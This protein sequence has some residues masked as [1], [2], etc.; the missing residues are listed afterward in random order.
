MKQSLKILKFLFAL[1]LIAVGFG[2]LNVGFYEGVAGLMI[3][4]PMILANIE[5]S[6]DAKQKRSQVYEK[7]QDMVNTRKSEQRSFTADEQIRYDKHKA[8]FDI[9]SNH[10]KEL[11][12]D[13]KRALIMAGKQAK[14]E[15]RERTKRSDWYD[16]NTGKDVIVLGKENRF[17]DIYSDD[18]SSLSVGRAVQGLISGNWRGAEKEERS[19]STAS[20]SG[21]L[22]PLRVFSS[23][24]DRARALSVCLN[25]GAKTIL[26]ETGSMT[27]AR[28]TNDASMQIK[29]ENDQ[30]GSNDIAFGGISLSAHTIGGVVTLSRE[31]ASDAPNVSQ[32]IEQALA[33]AIAVYLDR[34]ALTGTGEG[35]PRGIYNTIG[36]NDVVV[37]TSIHYGHLLRAW[38]EIANKNGKPNAVALNPKEFAILA[39][40]YHVGAGFIDPPNIIKDMQW[41]HSSSIPT[42]LGIGEDES[43]GFVG[44]FT[45]MFF[46]IREGVNIEV[47]REGGEKFS[48]HQVGVKITLRADVGIEQPS[49]FSKL[50][51]IESDVEWWNFMQGWPPTNDPE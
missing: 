39:G 12:D 5:T 4:A 6:D 26:M 21:L 38:Y 8:D 47:T 48:R 41:L 22:V 19:L 51:G 24:I 23:I 36:V 49:H 3:A 37:G 34:L 46:G 30:F 43:A 14:T 42:N 28:V 31:L 9:L 13:E 20:G 1:L 45:K 29:A 16:I 17:A 18:D 7:M 27:L 10:V 25:A 35:E 15:H 40:S 44:D 11:E 50:T 33:G 2:A 32:A